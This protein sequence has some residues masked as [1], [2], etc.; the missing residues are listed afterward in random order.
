MTT[1]RRAQ[2]WIAAAAT[3]FL[4]AACAGGA[5]EVRS[6]GSSSTSPSASASGGANDHDHMAAEDPAGKGDVRLRLEQV[7]GH[8]AVLMIRLMRGPIDNEPTFVA[9]A[10]GALDRNTDELVDAVAQAYGDDAGTQFRS[11]WEEHIQLLHEYSE[12][13]ADHDNKGMDKAMS[14]LEAYADRYG[15]LIATAT[16]GELSA[17]AVAAGVA[18]HIH[19]MIA[20]TDAYAAGNF[21]RAFHLQREAYA[22]MFGTAKSLAAAA[23]TRANGELPVAFDSTGENLRSGLGQLLGEHVELAFDATRAIVAGQPAAEGAAQTLNENTQDILTAMQG[24]VGD[25]DSAAF[26]RVWAEHINALVAFSVAV[27]DDNDKA[28]AAARALL[29]DFPGKLSALLAPLSQG[30]VAAQTVV[31]ALREHDQQLLQQVTAYAA[32]DYDT[33]HDL[34][35]AGYDHMFAI[36][37]TLAD[38][39]GGEAGGTAPHG[40]ADTGAGGAARR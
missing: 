28:Q 5:D 12:A 4:C 32:K 2:R 17:D 38:V 10:Q 19:H 8:H 20:A 6:A 25:Q 23:V 1:S 9:A 13:V 36:A 40:G 26:G 33:S 11:L 27:A 31:A 30:N 29:D 14:A 22:A 35:Y 15:K 7:L 3:V 18:E 37:A 16:D 34:A 21:T 39:L 24:A